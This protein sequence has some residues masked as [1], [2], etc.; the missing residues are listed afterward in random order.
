M[1]NCLLIDDNPAVL[2]YMRSYIEKTPFLNLI[3]TF[4][5]PADAL[6][7]LE[8]NTVQL[9]FMDIDLPGMT[10]IEFSKMLNAGNERTVPRIILI[11]S[12]ESFALD[13]Y[14]VNALDYLLKPISY[15]TF[16][17]AAYKAKTVISTP[18][19]SYSE[20]DHLFLRVEYELV[21]V[22]LKDV[23]YFEGFK[24]YV[25]VYTKNSPLFIK[26][27]TTIKNLEEKLPQGAFIRVH[28]SFI[29]SVDK[30]ESITKNT[31]KIG[32]MLIPVS[33][34]YKTEF[35]TFTDQWF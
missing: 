24:N 21:K 17:K 23:L 19:I 31:I 12:S 16:L 28:R 3:A 29:A 9:I 7:T 35:K 11:S 14:K 18:A 32:K 26:A 30:I 13:G 27:L 15:E 34:Q 10:G 22:Y 20:N 33:D 5:A 4:L 1:I 6:Q 8:S 25:K 2:F